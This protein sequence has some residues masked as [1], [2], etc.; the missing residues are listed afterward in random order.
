M[1]ERILWVTVTDRQF[2]PGTLALVNS[3]RHY[4]PNAEIAVIGSGEFNEGLAAAQIQLLEKG[5]IRVYR[6]SDFSNPGRVLGAW[7]LKAYAAHDLSAGYDMVIGADSDAVLCSNL[8]DIIRQSLADGKMR[9]GRDG[10]RRQYDADYAPYGFQT[11]ATTETYMS[12]LY[13]VPLNALNRS[14]LKEWA[15]AC[16]EAKFGP[17]PVKVYPG[18]GDQGVL[19]A[20]IFKHTKGANVELLENRLT[21]QH[22]T[23][24][25]DVV[26][27]GAGALVNRSFGNKPM[28]ALHNSGVANFWRPEHSEAL[29]VSGQNQTWSYAHWLWMLWFGVLTDWTLD[30]FEWLPFDSRHLCRDLVHYFHHIETIAPETVV[31]RWDEMT[32]PLLER[33]TMHSHRLMPLERSMKRY[34]KLGKQ[35][36]SHGRIVE[37]GSYFGGSAITLAVALL[38]RSVGVTSIESFMGNLDGTVDGLKLSSPAVFLQNVKGQFPHLNISTLPLDSLNASRKFQDRSL[39]MVFI[40]GNHSTAAVTND[41]D[42][43]LPKVKKGGVIAG[44]DISWGSV[45]KAVTQKFGAGY[46]SECDIWW[47][48]V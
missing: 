9:G 24:T 15:M 25:K 42:V 47:T 6:H 40:D 20:I 17:Q 4:H 37:V 21:S 27:Y 18:H 46:E 30:P 35:A 16:N 5:G 12:T 36:P 39:D 45:S 7:Q 13:F 1:T 2:F 38:H 41:I 10:D 28:R 19:N 31:K 44:D 34:I 23:Y 14:I 11:P 33:I 26:N 29:P 32:D 22:G 8:D 48:I 43:W 3:I